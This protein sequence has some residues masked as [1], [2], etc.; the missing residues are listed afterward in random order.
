MTARAWLSALRFRPRLVECLAAGYTRDDARADVLAGLTVGVVALPLAMAFA[1]ASGVTPQAGIFTAIIAGFLIS[2]L[3]GSRVQIGGP[4]GAYIVIVYAIVVH[5]GVANL[6]VCTIAAGVLLLA[7]GLT[8]VGG[9]IRFIP[10]AIVIGFT[11]GIA[12]L[13][14]LSQ[15]KEFLGLDIAMP[16][17][18]FTR[19]RAI[20]A[21]VD[22]VDPVTVAI[23]LICL[24]A[25]WLWPN[26]TAAEGQALEAESQAAAEVPLGDDARAALRERVLST[27]VRRGRRLMMRLPGPIVVLIVASAAVALLGLS[28][29][30]IGTRFGG[31]A[32]S[33]PAFAW[34]DISLPALRD[35]LAPTIT[36]ALLGA[37]ESLLS[38]R[39][40][41]TLIDDRHDPN[42]ELVAQGIANIVVPFF[43]GIPATGAIARTATN[44]RSGAR[45][46]VAGIVHALTLLAIVLVAAPLAKYVPLAALAAVLIVV[47]VN[48]GDWHAFRDLRRYSIPYRTVLLST[49]A[50][51]VVFGLTLAVEIGLVLSSLFFIY[52]VSELTKVEPITLDGVP[53]GI[54]AYKVF[55]SLFFG[56]VGKLEPL[57]DPGET[58]ARIVI[59][60]MHQVISIDNTGLETLH[61]LHR[62]LSRRGG[63][64]ILCGLNRHPAEQVARA[65]FVEPANVLPHLAAALFRTHQ[66]LR[67]TAPADPSATEW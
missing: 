18:F 4:T 65:A 51:T 63:T 53:P 58:P 20:A 12:V 52:R 11:N 34:P 14:L 56:S 38:A 43:G 15:M 16:D 49:F 23:A 64:L 36:I 50:I 10:V 26:A 67:D 48:M 19:M 61:A 29:E 46:P 7:M 42:Q 9:L 54:A 47:A 5:H 28:V 40:A 33:L 25:L 8:R 44:I 37:I 24:L 30:T 17:E 35:L 39:V 32:R 57:L 3:G 6:I 22:Q 62:S 21:N 27:T 60:E 41:D 59:L 66:I 31:I 55:G 2:A 13:I 1:I 45:T